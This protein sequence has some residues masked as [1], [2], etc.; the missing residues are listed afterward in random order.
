MY[1]IQIDCN[2]RKH[3]ENGEYLVCCPFAYKR[4]VLSSVRTVVCKDNKIHVGGYV[5]GLDD[6]FSVNHFLGKAE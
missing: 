4:G 1:T 5:F 6:F 3:L 2:G